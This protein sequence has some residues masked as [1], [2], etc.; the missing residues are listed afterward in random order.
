M[1]AL[2]NVD[3]TKSM[4]MKSSHLLNGDEQISPKRLLQAKQL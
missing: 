1:K 3:I 2:R 4:V